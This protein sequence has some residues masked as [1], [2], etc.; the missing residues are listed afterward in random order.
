MSER[1]RE[2]YDAEFKG[3]VIEWSSDPV[4]EGSSDQVVNQLSDHMIKW[5]SSGVSYLVIK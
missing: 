1:E 5:L 4:I 2:M 3:L